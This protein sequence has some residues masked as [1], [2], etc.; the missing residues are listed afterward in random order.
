MMRNQK[1]C[2]GV[3]KKVARSI[4]KLIGLVMGL[5]GMVLCVVWFGWKLLI[6]VMLIGW[7]SNVSG[8]VE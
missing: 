4:M 8:R 3:D 1:G 6:V 5:V 7:G 2:G